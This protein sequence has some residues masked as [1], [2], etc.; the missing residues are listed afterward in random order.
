MVNAGLPP[1]TRFVFLKQNGHFL[2]Q[3]ASSIQS[4]HGIAY[5]YKSSYAEK[6]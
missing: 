4:K 3:I 1:P 6:K 5:F 2:F